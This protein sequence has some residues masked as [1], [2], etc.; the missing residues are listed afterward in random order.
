MQVIVNEKQGGTRWPP[1]VRLPSPR[2]QPNFDSM[3]TVPPKPEFTE[4]EMDGVESQVG[5]RQPSPA[6]LQKLGGRVAY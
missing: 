4:H 1:G 5:T 3:P 2:R 6:V